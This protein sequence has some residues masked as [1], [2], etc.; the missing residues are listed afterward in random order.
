MVGEIFNS[1]QFLTFDCDDG[2]VLWTAGSWLHHQFSLF[3]A[4]GETDVITG[5][6]EPVHFQL[7][8][9]FTSGVGGA[10]SPSPL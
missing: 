7:H 9:L 2:V 10:L 1:L 5:C 6:G 4:D 3:G 8:L